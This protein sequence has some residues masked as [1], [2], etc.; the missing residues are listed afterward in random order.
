MIIIL[1]ND[2]K[3]EEHQIRFVDIGSLPVEATIDLLLQF[4]EERTCRGESAPFVHAVVKK[5]EWLRKES[6]T[7]ISHLWE[8]VGEHTCKVFGCRHS[9]ILALRANALARE[10]LLQEKKKIETRAWTPKEYPCNCS[11]GL[12]HDFVKSERP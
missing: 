5:A 1:D 11:S 9:E 6:L 2:E 12:L 7:P 10:T 8:R 3:Y 4:M